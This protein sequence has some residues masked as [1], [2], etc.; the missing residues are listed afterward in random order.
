[1]GRQWVGDK[2]LPEIWQIVD[3]KSH[4]LSQWATS[5]VKQCCKIEKQSANQHNMLTAESQL[6]D[7][8]P[9]PRERVHSKETSPQWTN[10]EK[11]Q[12]QSR[13]AGEPQSWSPEPEDKATPHWRRSRLS[14]CC[15][16]TGKKKKLPKHLARPRKSF[17]LNTN[18]R[19]GCWRHNTRTT[20]KT[21]I[22]LFLNL[23]FFY[24]FIC[25]FL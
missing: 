4:L 9:C 1:M 22:L 20:T 11:T 15:S 14:S 8:W 6:T 2:L 3:H 25:L 23:E 16:E 21:E 7:C 5:K 10:T 17:C 12:L 24:V 18:T 19:A 13:M